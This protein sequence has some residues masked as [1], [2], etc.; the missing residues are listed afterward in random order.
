M[1]E[2]AYLRH[3]PPSFEL[4]VEPAPEGGSVRFRCH[5]L[6]FIGEDSQ[7][8]DVQIPAVPEARRHRPGC[9]LAQ[10]VLDLTPGEPARVETKP[11]QSFVFSACHVAAGAGGSPLSLCY[12]GEGG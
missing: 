12:S 6:E 3:V 10:A 9:T 1:P 5:H 7:V 11:R 4:L 8:V 2:V